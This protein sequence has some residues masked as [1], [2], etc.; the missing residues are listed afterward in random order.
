MVLLQLQAE[1][2]F[3]LVGK[4]LSDVLVQKFRQL[5]GERVAVQVEVEVVMGRKLHVPYGANGCAYFR[6]DEL[7]NRPLGA[8]DYFGLF[9]K[10]FLIK[11]RF[12]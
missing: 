12:S 4:H 3:Y 8:A 10:P 6:F 5:T 2:G 7:C 1:Q 11:D 9:S